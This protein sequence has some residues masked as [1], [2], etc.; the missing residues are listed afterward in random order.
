MTFSCCLILSATY[1]PRGKP[2]G[3]S[4]LLPMCVLHEWNADNEAGWGGYLP[5][6]R[7]LASEIHPEWAKDYSTGIPRLSGPTWLAVSFQ[8]LGWLAKEF[9]P[10]QMIDYRI[11]SSTYK[12]AQWI[13][14]GHPHNGH[15]RFPNQKDARLK[16]DFENW[17]IYSFQ[18]TEILLQIGFC[19]ILKSRSPWQHMMTV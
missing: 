14:R 1:W 6:A 4:H 19:I 7:S 12:S 10:V 13:P 5:L 17:I 2:Q 16:L 11:Y 9:I 18:L 8:R 3:V 15:K